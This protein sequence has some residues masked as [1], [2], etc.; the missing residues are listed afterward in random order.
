M[1]RQR[2]LGGGVRCERSQPSRAVTWNSADRAVAQLTEFMSQL[3]EFISCNRHGTPCNSRVTRSRTPNKQTTGAERLHCI[4]ERG[5]KVRHF[6][7][8]ARQRAAGLRSLSWQAVWTLGI[9]GA[10]SGHMRCYER[11]RK[12]THTERN[13]GADTQH[14]YG[15]GGGGGRGDSTA[16]VT[17]AV[18]VGDA[19]GGRAHSVPPGKLRR[20]TFFDLGTAAVGCSD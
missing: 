1:R 19:S 13:R 4:C 16:A 5:P 8:V 10:P 18:D 9:R 14:R 11:T 7:L 2:E 20:A 17:T 15:P 12:R 3:T 6:L